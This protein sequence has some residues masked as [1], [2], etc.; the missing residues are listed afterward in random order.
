VDVE[1]REA[2]QPDGPAGRRPA[3]Q[4]EEGLHG[5]DALVAQVPCPEPNLAVISIRPFRCRM[6]CR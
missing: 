5:V 2:L 6:E 4:R 1:R 3:G